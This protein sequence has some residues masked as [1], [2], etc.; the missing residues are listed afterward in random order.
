M[1]ITPVEMVTCTECELHQPLAGA[2]RFCAAKL[3]EAGDDVVAERSGPGPRATA[4]YALLCEHKKEIVAW[5]D[6][7]FK[8]VPGTTAEVI[9]ERVMEQVFDELKPMTL[10]EKGMLFQDILDEVF[11]FGPLGPL[12]RDPEVSEIF[13]HAPDTVS[14][15]TD[16]GVSTVKVRFD[17]A[18]HMRDVINRFLAVAGRNL[19]DGDDLIEVRSPPGGFA[20]TAIADINGA[21]DQPIF[22]LRLGP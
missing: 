15:R 17:D 5:V 8:S 14:T 18:A 7:E 2:C 22:Y 21:G 6:R 20:F 19:D 1:S 11:G 4:D 9:R 16:A 12:L 3:S 10:F 13:I